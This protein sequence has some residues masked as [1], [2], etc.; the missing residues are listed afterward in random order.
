MQNITVMGLGAMGSALAQKLLAQGYPLTVYN[1]TQSKA[2]TLVAAGARWAESPRAAAANADVLLSVVGDDAASRAMWLGPDG[3]LAGAN[4]GAIAIESST[5]SLDWISEMATLA[6]GRGLEFVDAPLGG[7]PASVAAGTLNLF[8]GADPA[9]LESIRPVLAA[10]GNNILH[11]GPPTSGMTYK[12]INNMQVALHLAAL[13]EGVALAEKAG[14][15]M[16]TVAHALSTGGLSSPI[17]RSKLNAVVARDH[18]EVF[19]A[20]RWM[21]K[22]L[23]YALRAADQLGVPLPLVAGAHELFRMAMQRGLADLDW[24]AA[25]EVVRG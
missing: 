9:V 1:R 23:T 3:A 5:L 20:L 11:F 10:F 2:D 25:T 17:V 24:A 6:R 8:V 18:R 14:L 13:G 7:G 19:F 4:R 12:L 22:D 16:A 15:N 21:H